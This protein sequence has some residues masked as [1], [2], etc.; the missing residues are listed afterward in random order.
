MT[1]D[2]LDLDLDLG[3][4]RAAFAADDVLRLILAGSADFNNEVAVRELLAAVDERI[5][6][7]RAR[8]VVV[9]L[10]ALDFMN[11]SCFKQLISW[12]LAA[13]QH[14]EEQRYRIRLR[15]DPSR[16]WQKRSLTAIS[17]FG[18]GIVI[19]DAG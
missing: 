5:R 4:L 18:D 17:F 7:L 3:D 11:S 8:E 1:A 6:R 10:R 16:Y 12:I 13:R 15:V 14:P 19:V 2:D 9:D